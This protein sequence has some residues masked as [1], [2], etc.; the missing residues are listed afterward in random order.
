M[1]HIYDKNN[2]FA[3]R[4]M[5]LI[6]YLSKEFTNKGWLSFNLNSPFSFP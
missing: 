1:S 5:V 2:D 6:I 4:K 3:I